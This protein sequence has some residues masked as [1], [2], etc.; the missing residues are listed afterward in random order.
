VA[1]I[2]PGMDPYL[3]DPLIWRG[4]HTR[5]VVY[6]SDWLRPRLAPRYIAAVEERVYLQG[7]DRDIY[8]DV[9]LRQGEANGATPTLAVAS[10]D[11]PVLVKVPAGEVHEPFLQILDMSSG[12]AVVTVIEVLSP[13]NK[14]PG[15]GRKQ[16][17]QKQ[18]EVRE[19]TAHL[20]EIDLLRTGHHT[21]AVAEAACRALRPYDYLACLNR[22]AGLREDFELWRWPLRSRLPRVLVPLAAG[23]PDVRLDLQEV[24]A[25]TYEAGSYRARL[26]YKEPCRPALNAEDQAW[27]DEVI[28]TAPPPSV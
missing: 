24:F 5:F 28:R 21:V 14:W 3:E 17:L 26:P 27:A 1:A 18:Q 23:D 16:Y 9:W 15:T 20:L 6:L 8:P 2:F 10:A 7:P 19:S 13:S 22:A 12:Q 4:F 25:Q 11:T